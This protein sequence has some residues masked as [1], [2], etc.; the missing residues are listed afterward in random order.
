MNNKTEYKVLAFQQGQTKNGKDMW[1]ITLESMED[2]KPLTGVI[3]SEDIPR[4]DGVQFKTGNIIKFLGQDYNSNYNS[5]VIKNV[6]V[7]KEAISGVP[8]A[9]SN[10]YLNDILGYLD[11]VEQKYSKLPTTE[12]LKTQLPYSLLATELKKALKQKEF[13]ITPAAE[14]FHHNYLG[15]LLKHTYEVLHIVRTLSRMFP[16]EK[17]DALQ[18]AAILHDLGKMYEY[19]TDVKLGTATIDQEF[20]TNEISHVHWGY[21]FAHDVAAFDVARMVAS[22][23]GKVEW[24]AI[25]EPETSEEKVLHL[26]DMI[27][28]TIGI[29]T[30]DKL[31]DLLEEM[32]AADIVKEVQQENEE[33]VNVHPTSDD[34]L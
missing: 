20:I 34:V 23:H 11:E 3:W 29:T 26:A 19:T 13:S 14:R 9:V 31:S 16:I 17:L 24:G 15:G 21:R 4:F 32:K 2:K 1:R 30:V 6:T 18:L 7:I 10:K 33:A 12:D 28:A 25:F 27:S 5:V 22:H 8:E